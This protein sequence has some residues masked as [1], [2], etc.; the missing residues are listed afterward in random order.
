MVPIIQILNEEKSLGRVHMLDRRLQEL[1]DDLDHL[2]GK[3]LQSKGCDDRTL[4]STFQWLLFAN[5]PLLL[6][7]LYFATITSDSND[8]IEA[9][10]RENVSTTDMENFILS[11]SKG[12]VEVSKGEE[13]IVQFIHG[14]VRD[15]LLSKGLSLLHHTTNNADLTALCH[16][17]LKHCCHQYKWYCLR[18]GMEY[19]RA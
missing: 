8:S 10:D 9:W 16:D 4:L 3:I 15:Y 11:S 5:R 12:L 1:P 7:E 13:R 19:E 18:Q 2:F 17:R 14:F 6:E